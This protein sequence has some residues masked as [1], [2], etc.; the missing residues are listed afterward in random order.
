M[1]YSCIIRLFLDPGQPG[2]RAFLS[3]LLP[4]FLAFLSAL[5]PTF[6]KMFEK[7]KKKMVN[8]YKNQFSTAV[9]MFWWMMGRWIENNGAE[10][11]TIDS[12]KKISL[13]LPNFK[14]GKVEAVVAS[15][16]S[17]K[18]FT[19]FESK[20]LVHLD[21]PFFIWCKSLPKNCKRHAYKKKNFFRIEKSD[22]RKDWK[23]GT[24]RR[25]WGFIFRIGK[26]FE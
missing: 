17:P 5:F 3:A 21:P 18:M 13:L 22:Q 10:E 1:S 26:Y 25:F 11:T 7:W 23:N 15:K 14:W 9:V 16:R 8:K 2:K 19:Y 12:R 20:N 6:L 4:T 24:C